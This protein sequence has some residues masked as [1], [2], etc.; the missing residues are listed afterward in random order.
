M[1]SEQFPNVTLSS[2]PQPR[3]AP[4]RIVVEGLNEFTPNDPAR[5]LVSF[6]NCSEREL[7][8]GSGPIFP[9]SSI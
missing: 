1:V 9:F 5:I 2:D 3:D 8:V 7:T 6:E 4:V